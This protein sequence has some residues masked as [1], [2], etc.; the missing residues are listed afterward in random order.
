MHTPIRTL[1]ARCTPEK[2]PRQR[3]APA[4]GK[5]PACYIPFMQWTIILEA[6]RPG[7]TGGN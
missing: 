5:R 1:R 3:A 7:Q 4:R 6:T 2:R